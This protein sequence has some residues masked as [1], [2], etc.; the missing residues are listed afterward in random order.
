M[1]EDMHWRQRSRIKWKKGITILSSSIKQQ[2]ARGKGKSLNLCY[3]KRERLRNSDDFSKEMMNF[4]G[5]FILT[6]QGILR[7]GLD[8]SPIFAVLSGWS[9]KHFLEE[10]VHCAVFPTE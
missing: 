8:W 2:M 3:L 6:W 9:R 10:K 1:K 4:L 5:S 7:E